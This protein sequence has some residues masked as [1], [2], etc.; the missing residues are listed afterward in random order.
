M[1]HLEGSSNPILKYLF[2]AEYEDGSGVTQ[3]PDDTSKTD[4]KRSAFFDVDQ[5]KVS[6]FYLIGAH[7]SYSVDLKD[8]HFEINGT[9]FRF[10]EE[11]EFPKDAKL[12][13]IFFRRHKHD[14]TSDLEEKSHSIVYRLGWQTNTAYGRNIQ[15]VMEI[16]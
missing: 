3:S 8:G 15:H 10:H 2:Y 1:T 5:E 6:A 14:F 4:P 13:L 11:G 16:D 7:H 12:R 9:S